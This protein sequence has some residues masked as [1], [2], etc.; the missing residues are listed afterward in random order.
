M[1]RFKGK[2]YVEKKD[3]GY[4]SHPTENIMLREPKPSKRSR[5]QYQIPNDTK[6]GKNQRVIKNENIELVVNRYP[7]TKNRKIK[8]QKEI[9][10]VHVVKIMI[11]LN[12]TKDI[13]VQFVNLLIK[14]QNTK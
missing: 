8:N 12:L 5:T 1:K 6:R 10:S 9:W 13:T 3:K 7:K 2:F 4:F 11:A 14:N